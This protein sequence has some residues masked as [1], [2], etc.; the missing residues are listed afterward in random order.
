[1]YDIFDSILNTTGDGGCRAQGRTPWV[2]FI[3]V[4]LFFTHV[5]LSAQ[6]KPS[7]E[8]PPIEQISKNEYQFELG[9]MWEKESL[10]WFGLTYGRNFGKCYLINKECSQY[11]DVTGGVGGREAFSEGLVLAGLRWQLDYLNFG[12]LLKFT[13]AFKFF[14]GAINIRDNS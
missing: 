1:M 3:F 11:F 14:G 7:V 9:S 4:F 13:P 2:F 10:Y 8:K 5:R 12:E 6:D